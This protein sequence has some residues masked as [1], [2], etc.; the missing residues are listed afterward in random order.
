MRVFSSECLHA[1]FLRLRPRYSSNRLFLI[2]ESYAG[3][4]VP[5][6]ITM[7]SWEPGELDT[8]AVLQRSKNDYGR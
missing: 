2:G 4:Y 7:G 3:L 8:L 6:Q 5:G 1:T